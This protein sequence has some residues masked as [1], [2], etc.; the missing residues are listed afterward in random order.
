MV[1]HIWVTHNQDTILEKRLEVRTTE[2]GPVGNPELLHQ[3]R[4]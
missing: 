4:K 3:V 2:K 1:W